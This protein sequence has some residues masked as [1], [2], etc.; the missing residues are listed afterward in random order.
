MLAAPEDKSLTVIIILKTTLAMDVV[1]NDFPM[2]FNQGYKLQVLST[3]CARMKP[4]R[5]VEK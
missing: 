5:Y 4:A 1:L 3:G 2:V